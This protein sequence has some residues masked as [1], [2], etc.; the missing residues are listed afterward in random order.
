MFASIAISGLERLRGVSAL[1]AAVALAMLLP[2]LVAA[3]GAANLTAVNDLQS[4]CRVATG[5]VADQLSVSWSGGCVSGAANGVGDVF[6]FS[7]GRLRYIQRGEFRSGQLIRQDS[8]RDCASANCADDVPPSLLR[9]HEQ[10]AASRAAPATP[11]IPAPAGARPGL[12]REIRAADAVYRGAFTQDPN[13]GTV[14]GEGKVEFFDGRSYQGTLKNSRKEG[15]GTY[16]WADGN[17]YAGAWANDLQDGQGEWST[18]A[19]DRYVGAHVA[20]RREGL[21]TMTYASGMRYEGDWKADRETGRGK[22]Q[23]VNGDSYEGDFVQGE[24][25]GTGVYRQKGVSA[26]TGQ[27][28]KGLREGNGVEEWLNGQRYEGA[29]RANMKQGLGQMRYADGGTFDGDWRSDQATGQGDIVFASG[30]VYTGQVR[31]GQPQGNG[32]FRWGSGDRFEGEFDA[33]KPTSKG[34]MTFMFS[35]AAASVPAEAATTPS[36]PAAANPAST[37]P[38]DAAVAQSRSGLCSTAFNSASTAAALRRFL[39]SYPDDE[40]ARHGL[41]KQKIAALAERER[42][43]ARATDEKTA[44]AKTLIGAVVAFQQEFTFCVVGTGASCQRAT[45]VFDVKA[46]IRDIDV[47]KRS[48]RVQISEATSLGNVKR[49]PNQL[50]TEGRAAAALEYKT[51]NL[52]VI[53]SKSLDEIGLAF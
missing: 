27:W 13:S 19:G 1:A 17:R 45:Y 50:F 5:L 32:I 40:C 9:L 29:W 28:L 10:A 24:R 4:N 3:Q 21:G 26:Y 43:A 7:K 42:L 6:V 36:A 2:R 20:S 35:V 44:M 18:K 31:S 37:P 46:K 23:F 12:V 51:K 30:D 8:L 16:I 53:Q 48:A 14:S 25:T 52:G 49:S 33:G 39:D 38:A 15:M 22:L 34:E 41:A 47:Q 11:E